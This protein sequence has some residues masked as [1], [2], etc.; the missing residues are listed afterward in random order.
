M[1]II[2]HTTCF[3]FFKFKKKNNI[4]LL[5][6]PYNERAHRV[7]P[8]SGVCRRGCTRESVCVRESECAGETAKRYF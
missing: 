3:I 2:T 4:S 7:R 6:E 8:E 5:L 1:V